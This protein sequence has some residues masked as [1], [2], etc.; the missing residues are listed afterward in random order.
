MILLPYFNNLLYDNTINL[1]EVD[2]ARDR[3]RFHELTCDV[4]DPTFHAFWYR[5]WSAEDGRAAAAVA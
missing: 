1:N 2:A 3:F 4:E 5:Q